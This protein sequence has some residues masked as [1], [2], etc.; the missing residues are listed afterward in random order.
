MYLC[1]YESVFQRDSESAHAG[2]LVA[3]VEKAQK[4][5]KDAE[6]G[7][8]K[9]AK[10]PFYSTPQKPNAS[11]A[12]SSSSKSSP[13]FHTP[14]ESLKMTFSPLTK[15]S[16]GSIPQGSTLS[17]V[18]AHLFYFDT[19]QAGFV[20]YLDQVVTAEIRQTG[21]YGKHFISKIQHFIVY[22]LIVSKKDSTPILLQQLEQKMNPFCDFS[23]HS[24]TWVWFDP[25]SNK[26]F[27]SWSLHFDPE[28]NEES[29]FNRVFYG[30][31]Y[32]S[33]NRESL[34]KTKSDQ[35]EYLQ[36]VFQD[37]DAMDVDY[38]A[39]L[40]EEEYDVEEPKKTLYESVE[41][42]QE[43]EN[44]GAQNS[45]LAVG[46]KNDR[47]FVVRGNKIGVFKHGDDQLEFS[48]AIKYFFGGV[49]L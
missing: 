9:P 28:S 43:Q 49:N 39:E 5:A 17:K 26:P 30:S 24:F 3:F 48:T 20:Q 38:E 37:D 41:E 27:V 4:E 33:V 42:Q 1:L 11:K 45:L 36:Q 32:E 35:Q 10:N 34:A 22:H 15:H 29:S 8:W 7:V 31:M 47:S 16:S 46:Y 21:E 13:A 2:D 19:V 12:P 6:I 40:Q 23:N 25:E 18:S 44:D 14:K